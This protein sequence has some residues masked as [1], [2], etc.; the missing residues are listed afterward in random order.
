[1]VIG[2]PRFAT[3]IV[4][5]MFCRVE[6]NVTVA[7]PVPVPAHGGTSCAAVSTAPNVCAKMFA[8]ESRAIAKLTNRA[9]RFISPPLV[10]G[11][12]SAFTTCRLQMLCYIAVMLDFGSGGGRRR[13]EWPSSLHLRLDSAAR[14]RLSPAALWR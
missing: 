11:D 12:T 8:V 3:V 9:R 6:S 7:F 2:L 4:T 10:A 14:V 5:V 1:M 13:R